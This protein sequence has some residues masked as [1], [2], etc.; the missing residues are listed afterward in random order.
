MKYCGNYLNLLQF[1]NSKKN[2]FLVNYIGKYSILYCKIFRSDIRA[3]F[4][5]FSKIYN[6]LKV[7]CPVIIWTLIHEKIRAETVWL[8]FTVLEAFQ[9]EFPTEWDSLV[10]WDKGTEHSSLSRDKGT[11]W[12]TQNLA[13]GRWDRILT[14]RHGMGQDRTGF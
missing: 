8:Y 4:S 13:M 14:F 6:S 12:K 3:A 7:T 2:G 5:C 9:I 11:I 1:S 10:S